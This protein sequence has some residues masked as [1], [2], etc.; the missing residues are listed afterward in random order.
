MNK[1]KLSPIFREGKLISLKLSYNKPGL[2]LGENYKP[3]KLKSKSSNTFTY[4][5][6]VYDS[7]LLLPSS[8][9]KLA[10]AFKVEKQKGFFPLKFLDN[11]VID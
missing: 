6:M 11:T 1:L 4:S 2:A 5:L 7:L 10:K 8:L 3:K 9:D